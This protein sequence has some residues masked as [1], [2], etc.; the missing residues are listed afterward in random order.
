MNLL[1][2]SVYAAAYA[3]V[4]R[5]ERHLARAHLLH[6]AA[7][8][9]TIGERVLV[10][11]S[12][13]FHGDPKNLTIGDD[14]T[15]NGGAV[16]NASA[17]LTLGKNVRVSN[18]AQLQTDEL[19]P[20]SGQRHREHRFAS[21]VVGDGAWLAAGSV[22]VPGVSIGAG[23]IVAAGAVVTK[24]VD[25]FVLVAGVPARVVRSLR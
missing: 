16:L 10:F 6:L 21:V 4:A 11:G 19:V 22:V 1:R 14:C 17:P 13:V 25:A 20:E 9:A 23:A 12:F 8:G 3:V 5:A 18:Q 2:R 24:D 15:I 7:R